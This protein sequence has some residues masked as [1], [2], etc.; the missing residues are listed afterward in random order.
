MPCS[1]FGMCFRLPSY[2]YPHTHTHFLEKHTWLT[3]L[4]FVPVLPV[5]VNPCLSTPQPPSPSR[6]SS[7]LWSRASTPCHK[8]QAIASLLGGLVGYFRGGIRA[9]KPPYSILQGLM[10]FFPQVI[11]CVSCGPGLGWNAQGSW[12]SFYSFL[13]LNPLREDGKSQHN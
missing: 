9:L 6:G 1:Y 5:A 12:R 8:S 11:K 3:P 13:L 7:T 2:S 10:I 4:V